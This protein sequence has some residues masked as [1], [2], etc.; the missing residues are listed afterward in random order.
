M[1]FFFC[2]FVFWRI[3]CLIDLPYVTLSSAP[4]IVFRNH[5]FGLRQFCVFSTRWE[6]RPWRLAAKSISQEHFRQF[7]TQVFGDFKCCFYFFFFCCF[8]FTDKSAVF[9]HL[10]TYWDILSGDK[11]TK[12]VLKG[13]LNHLFPLYQSMVCLCASKWCVPSFFSAVE[14]TFAR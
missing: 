7:H 6:R 2:S 9:I 4:K 10:F 14:S 12:T 13:I 11:H 1:V 8:Y 3:T 5:Q